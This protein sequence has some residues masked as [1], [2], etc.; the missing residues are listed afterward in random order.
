MSELIIALDYPDAA[1]ALAMAQR[2]A[3]EKVILKVGK[4]LF[5]SAGP[6]LV[7]MT[8]PRRI[9]PVRCWGSASSPACKLGRR[10]RCWRA[11]KHP[12][13]KDG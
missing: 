1:A 7:V 6:A 9:W 13:C 4:E 3:P 8:F 10:A 5:V 12:G 2:L 11:S